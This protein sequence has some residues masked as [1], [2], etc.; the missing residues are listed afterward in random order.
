MMILVWDDLI[1]SKMYD[2]KRQVT[3]HSWCSV[4][5]ENC[6][7]INTVHACL[8]QKKSSLSFEG[9]VLTHYWETLYRSGLSTYNIN[10]VKYLQLNVIANNIK[11]KEK[12]KTIYEACSVRWLK[13]RRK[14][15]APKVLWS[16]KRW[17]LWQ[18]SIKC[19]QQF[20]LFFSYCTF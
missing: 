8:L 19:S 1:S 20:S 14:D 6:Q 17:Q 2:A 9:N 15:S 5:K 13:K 18:R 3:L 11:K 4:R 16:T 7:N 12:K 10:T